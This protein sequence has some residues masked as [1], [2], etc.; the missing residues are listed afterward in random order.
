M[1]SLR[2]R[3]TL[4]TAVAATTAATLLVPGSSGATSTPTSNA[5]S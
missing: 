5:W 2:T 4:A 3:A 1:R